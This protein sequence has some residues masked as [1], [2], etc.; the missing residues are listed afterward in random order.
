M[1]EERPVRA[2][3]AVVC[4]YGEAPH[5]PRSLVSL[6]EQEIPKGL[7][8]EI[9]CVDNNPAPCA[10]LPEPLASR[11][12]VIH[13]PVAGLSRARN[14]A[15]AHAQGDTI[16]FLDDD[17]VAR[18]GWATALA[19]AFE[20]THAWC[21]GGRVLPEW[22]DEE[23]L[24]LH[25]KLRYLLGLLDLSNEIRLLHGP[26]FPCG[27]NMAVR[28][29]AFDRVGLFCESLGRRPGSLLSGEEI[30][31]FRRALRAGGT[32]AYA[33]DA[34]V[35]HIVPSSRLSPEFL[36]RR[37]WWEGN[38]LARL[39][40]LSGGWPLAMGSALA[41]TVLALVR[42]PATGLA[43]WA[44]QRSAELAICRAHKVAGYWAGLFAPID[45]GVLP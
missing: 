36:R 32:V 29:F 43:A 25:S 12:R 39:D 9:L 44:T 10:A 17:A 4:T 28:R 2:I 27:A 37:A 24:W 30:D 11:V 40:R 45:R 5:L 7:T 42:E 41:R 1:S 19:C 3:T 33:P 14:A 18:P 22:P 16:A 15:V 8:L 34:T 21:V 31:L 38:T 35:H 20:T 23:P 6:A 13:E 26:V